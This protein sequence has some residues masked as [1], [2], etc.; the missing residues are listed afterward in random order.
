MMKKSEGFS[1]IE[2]LVV[3]A[4]IGVLA[5]V[6][7]VGYQ[8]YIDNTRRD[9][10]RTNA[11]SVDRWV[12]STQIAR[13][14]GL[15]ISPGT[16]SWEATT[17]LAGCWGNLAQNANDPF[18]K[19]KNPYQAGD[20]VPLIVF[21]GGTNAQLGTGSPACTTITGTVNVTRVKAAGNTTAP[22]NAAEWRGVTIVNR[23]GG[24]ADNLTSTDNELEI[25][26]CDG[27]SAFVQLTDNTS[28]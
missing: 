18:N 16:C 10:A 5:A 2:L 6:G 4:I 8:T 14:G 22:A 21:R 25:G 28:F 23:I 11:E 1:L 7:I 20:G 24:T 13:A 19:F 12:S 3:V 27:N 9:V 17:N 26:Y 15:T